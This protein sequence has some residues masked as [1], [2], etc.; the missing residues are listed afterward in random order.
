MSS[1]L[2]NYRIQ[3]Q[4][5]EAA[6]VAE[7]NNEELLKLQGDLLE[8]IHLQEEILGETTDQDSTFAS[9]AG[10]SEKITWKVGL[11]LIAYMI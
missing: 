1:E 8:V 3:L 9:N 6:L 5:V 11:L 4:Q 7:P 2:E 10:S